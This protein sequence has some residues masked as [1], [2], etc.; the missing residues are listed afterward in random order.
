MGFDKAIARFM[1]HS[2]RYLFCCIGDGEIQPVS[3]SQAGAAQ[4][5]TRFESS[6]D[7]PPV[8]EAVASLDCPVA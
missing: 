2:K 6:T 4:N 1:A 7:S 5:I 3:I 8:E